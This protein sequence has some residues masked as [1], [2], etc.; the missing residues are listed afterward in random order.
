MILLAFFIVYHIIPFLHMNICINIPQFQHCLKTKYGRSMNNC[1]ACA[2]LSS[3]PHQ[4]RFQLAGASV[5]N[6]HAG[7]LS[8]GQTLI[9]EL[10][11]ARSKSEPSL[12]IPDCCRLSCACGPHFQWKLHLLVSGCSM[13]RTLL[14]CP[15]LGW[16]HPCIYIYTYIC[17]YLFR[18]AILSYQQ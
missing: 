4:V 9:A 11:R 14:Q 12:R 15:T 13:N 7:P 8:D 2:Q 10:K 1:K 5:W 16:S 6:F 18:L 3:S 17:I